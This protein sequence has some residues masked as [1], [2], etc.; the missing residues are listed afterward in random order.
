MYLGGENKK[1]KKKILLSVVVPALPTIYTA[2]TC[3][4]KMCVDRN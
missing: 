3:S 4:S 1:L 2:C